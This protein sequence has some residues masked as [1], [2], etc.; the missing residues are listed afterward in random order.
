MICMAQ[1]E[2]R[3]GRIDRPRRGWAPKPVRPRVPCQVVRELTYVF[4]GVCA[5]LGRL[6][7][8]LLPAA[9]TEMMALFLQ[10]GAQAF[11]DD[12]IIMPV[13][14]ASWHTSQRLAVPENIRLI[15]QPAG[16]PEL[17]PTEHLW[18]ALRKSA[19]SNRSFPS[20]DALEEALGTAINQ[21][22]DDP[23]SPSL[24]D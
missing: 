13:D 1:E 17:N 8:L 15:A 14:R 21:L 12:C 10:Q 20:M 2:G 19:L 4:A 9:N 6:T 22:A 24:I 5:A 3:F 7:A 23:P 16:S 18:K 11:S